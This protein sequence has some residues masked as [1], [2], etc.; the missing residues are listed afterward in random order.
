[1]DSDSR[2]IGG[3]ISVKPVLG[4]KAEEVIQKKEAEMVSEPKVEVVEL[5]SSPKT[6]PKNERI[7]LELPSVEKVE[8]T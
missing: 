1:M 7:E 4:K 3:G 5:K 8:V 2:P 6:S